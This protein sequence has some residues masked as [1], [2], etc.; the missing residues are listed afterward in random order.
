MRFERAPHGDVSSRTREA[1]AGV[2]WRSELPHRNVFS[3]GLPRL[4]L[5]LQSQWRH[6]KLPRCKDWQG[7]LTS[8]GTSQRKEFLGFVLGLAMGR[9]YGLDEG[10]TT[11][12]LLQGPGSSRCS[13][14]TKIDEMFWARCCR[15]LTRSSFAAVDNLYCIRPERK[16]PPKIRAADR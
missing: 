3:L 7:N 13:A 6:R 2:A 12:I 14:Q 11:P 15:R 5:H 16:A 4:R 1:N 8:S 10:G 9:I